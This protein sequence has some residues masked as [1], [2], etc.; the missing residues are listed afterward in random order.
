[1]GEFKLW[2]RVV[3][4]RD[5]F[6]CR[7]YKPSIG[8]IG[9]VRDISSNG[10]Y[11]V[12]FGDDENNWTHCKDIELILYDDTT[13][14]FEKIVN[15]NFNVKEIYPESFICSEGSRGYGKSITTRCMETEIKVD[16]I[17][18]KIVELENK[19][20]GKEMKNEVLELWYRRKQEQIEK[21]YRDL[22]DKLEKENELINAYR[23]LIEDFEKSM[24]DLYEQDDNQ[25][26]NIIKELYCDY[27]YK[28]GLN[29][30]LISDMF[31]EKYR[32][33]MQERSNNL[34]KTYK[35]VNAQLSLSDDLDYQIE[36]LINYGILD[37]KT[38][39]MVD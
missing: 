13:T 27:S 37:K 31:Y 11:K 1:M 24:K 17:H 28:Y 15:G 33:E 20:E 6:P 8:D 39:K 4:V 29:R 12:I 26:Q 16:A 32:D 35:E 14:D 38:K 34:Y 5:T 10:R 25:E 23:T 21:E 9:V 30:E 2:D 18:T 7:N 22:A 19:M 3:F 36:T